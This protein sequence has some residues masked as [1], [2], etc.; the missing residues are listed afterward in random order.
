MLPNPV[1]KTL[2]AVLLLTAVGVGA[3]P[4]RSQ[5]PAAAGLGLAEFEELKPPLDLR[6]QP[7]ATIPWK[8]SLTEARQAAAVSRKPIFMVVN[9]G[10]CLGCV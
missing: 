6:N 10:N 2:A 7:W 8:Y 5:Q 3:G 4:A 9:T 1:R